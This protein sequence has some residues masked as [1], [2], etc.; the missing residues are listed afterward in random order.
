MGIRARR[1]GCGNS[2]PG[3]LEHGLAVVDEV[4]LAVVGAE[5]LARQQANKTG[6]AGDVEDGLAW[7]DVR[8]PDE[9]LVA[10]DAREVIGGPHADVSSA[11]VCVVHAEVLVVVGDAVQ[12]LGRGLG[13]HLG[14]CGSW[15]RFWV[16]F[17]AYVD[18]RGSMVVGW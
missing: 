13:G 11:V 10:V 18:C 8:E 5:H 16:R 3:L 2:R 12:G 6:T 7:L 15:I 17:G 9:S 14:G 4:D 1:S